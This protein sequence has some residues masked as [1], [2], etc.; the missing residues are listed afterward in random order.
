MN[1]KMFKSNSR[2]VRILN[3]VNSEPPR[4]DSH[5]F[6]VETLEDEENLKS[7]KFITFYYYSFVLKGIV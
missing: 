7:G 6:Q 5:L 2:S 3:L 1:S 4:N